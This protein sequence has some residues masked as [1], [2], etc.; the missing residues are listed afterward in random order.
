ML[1]RREYDA[2][3]LNVVANH[4]EVR[5]LVASGSEPIDLSPLLAST[6][7]IALVGEAGGVLLVRRGPG[8]YEAH[9]QFLPEA[10]GS[11]AV[12]AL[13]EALDWLFARTDALE[14]WA[15]PSASAK[16]VLGLC[17]ALHFRKECEFAG[18]KCLVVRM[19]DWAM[20]SSEARNAGEEFLSAFEIEMLK[21]GESASLIEGVVPPESALLGVLG[22]TLLALRA[23]QL[24]KALLLFNRWALL[25]HFAPIRLLS[26]WPITFTFAHKVIVLDDN[27]TTFRVLKEQETRCL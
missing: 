24:D 21:Q 20:T 16:R 9:V 10:W 13:R 14:V 22:A 8:V 12:E 19:S 3:K 25:A 5:P 7:N 18:T 17:R 1:L 15:Q 23:C 26:P 4:P 27:K 6:A 11:F 2:S